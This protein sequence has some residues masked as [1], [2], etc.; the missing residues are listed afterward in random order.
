MISAN[1]ETEVRWA[2]P[3]ASQ[4]KASKKPNI[5]EKQP[6]KQKNG[7]DSSDRMLQALSSIL[8]DQK[9]IFLG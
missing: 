9:Q 7:V 5:S 8:Q 6:Q 3:K 2:Q 4:G 1:W